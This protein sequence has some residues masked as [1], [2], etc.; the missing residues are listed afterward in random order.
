MLKRITS[1]FHKDM[2]NPILCQIYDSSPP[3]YQ[4]GYWRQDSSCV[5]K[6]VPGNRG[7]T[8]IVMSL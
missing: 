7:Q 1:E 6:G 4:T 5:G 3:E 2:I 8:Q